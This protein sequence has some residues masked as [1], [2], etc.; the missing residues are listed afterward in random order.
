VNEIF[1]AAREVDEVLASL[2]LHYCLIGGL[3][4][5]RWGRPRGTQDVDVSVFV[6]LGAERE[7]CEALVERLRPRIDDPVP[8][9]VANRI[10]LV[11]TENGVAV[12][13]ALAAF[14]FEESMIGRATPFAFSPD[15]VIPTASAEDLIVLKALA[16]RGHDWDDVESMIV[17]QSGRLDWTLIIEQIE[18]LSE[19]LSESDAIRKLEELRDRLREEGYE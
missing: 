15:V 4:V 14:A 12:D 9:A 18:G 1:R 6:E 7:I 5:I 16:G 11:E 13:I 3:A 8:F 19:L 10:L 2:N 17:R